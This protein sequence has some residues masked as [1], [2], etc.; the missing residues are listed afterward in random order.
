[1]LDQ[2][3]AEQYNDELAKAE[4]TK[5]ADALEQ[6]PLEDLI[7]LAQQHGVVPQDQ[8]TTEQ[9]A[10]ETE[11]GKLAQADAWGREL[12][13]Q[14]VKLAQGEEAA[15]PPA[16]PPAGDAAPV[17]AGA[18]PGVEIPPGDPDTESAAALGEDLA[19]AVGSAILAAAASGKKSGEGQGDAAM[20]GVPPT[21]MPAP[22]GAPVPVAAPPM[23]T[24][25]ASAGAAA[26]VAPAAPGDAGPP[27]S[28]PAAGAKTAS[29]DQRVFGILKTAMAGATG[30]YGPGSM[31]KESGSGSECATPGMKIRSGGK[32]RGAAV[33]GG[34][35]PI[36]IPVALKANAAKVKAAQT[37]APG[38]EKPDL[39]KTAKVFHILKGVQCP[40]DLK[41]ESSLTPLLIGAGTGALRSGATAENED[42]VQRMMGGA[43]LGGIGGAAA[44][45][46]GY[47]PVGQA[48]GGLVG[49][50]FSESS[51]A[52][53]RRNEKKK[54]TMEKHTKVAAVLT[55]ARRDALSSKQFAV[56]ERKAKKIGVAGEIKGEAK[57]KYPIPNE[58]HARN[59]LSRVAQYGTPAEKKLVRAKVKAKF[60]DIGEEKT[61]RY[62]G[63]FRGV[64]KDLAR[65]G[66]HT[67]GGAAKGGL[68][69]AGVGHVATAPAAAGAG[70]K[71]RIKFLKGEIAQA[72]KDLP[73]RKGAEKE[74]IQQY[75]TDASNE[76]KE[77]QTDPRARAQKILGSGTRTGA[78]VGAVIG[79]LRGLMQGAALR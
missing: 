74:M 38:A 53:K 27:A 32:G 8:V 30:D 70:S 18:G 5:L 7:A 22:A 35:G 28:A 57:G 45:R 33:G 55:Q 59:A 47:G 75:I 25:Q 37:S 21:A 58:S 24:P 17:E 56:P 49:G 31:R 14:H 61:A 9:D 10:R 12:A 42:L 15:A 20:P 39:S 34:K 44:S 68:V 3:L 6:L 72:K 62:T 77:H 4:E 71:D 69:G 52:V 66:L 19:S 1:M 63:M 29:V 60:P 48:V 16:G 79:G 26:P 46:L 43:L 54:A 65:M 41:K 73:T 67:L 51:T 78:G 50:M 40:F 13:H 76:L 36:G 2:W 11:L 23:P 64:G